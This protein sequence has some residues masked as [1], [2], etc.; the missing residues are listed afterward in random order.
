MKKMNGDLMYKRIK[1]YTENVIAGSI[2]MDWKY[3]AI[4]EDKEVFL[5]GLS[6]IVELTQTIMTNNGITFDMV[7]LVYVPYDGRKKVILDKILD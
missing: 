5:C 1:E 3:K 6:K 2:V 7:S 4:G